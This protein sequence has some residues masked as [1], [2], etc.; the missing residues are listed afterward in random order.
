MFENGRQNRGT[1]GREE[2]GGGWDSSLG[3]GRVVGSKTNISDYSTNRRMDGRL[4]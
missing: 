4:L 3:E 2:G 1:Y